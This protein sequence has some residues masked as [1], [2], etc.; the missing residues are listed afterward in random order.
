MKI[1]RYFETSGCAHPAIQHHNPVDLKP[2]DEF[3]VSNESVKGQKVMDDPVVPV[4]GMKAVTGM[5]V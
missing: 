1:T 2:Q 3:Y 5:V 4:H